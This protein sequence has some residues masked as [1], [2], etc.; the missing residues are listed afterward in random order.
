MG[1]GRAAVPE[2]HAAAGQ[3]RVAAGQNR[4]AAGQNRVAA[5]Q[6]RAAPSKISD[7]EQT[8]RYFESIKDDPPLLLAFLR[9]MP[10]GADLHNH[11]S[12]AVYAEDYIKMALAGRLC[13]NPADK[14]LSMPPCS[15]GQQI[16][17][18]IKLDSTLYDKLIDAWSMRNWQ[19][20]GESGHDHFFAAF[21]KFGAA[22][23]D[24]TLSEMLAAALGQAAADHVGSVELMFTPNSA[25]IRKIAQGRWNDD[26]ATMAKRIMDAGLAAEVKAGL[27]LVKKV[28]IEARARMGCKSAAPR[29]GC[30]VGLRFLFQGQRGSPREQAFALFLAG[31]EMVMHPENRDPWTGDPLVV[32]VNLVQP[33]D[34]LAAIQDFSAQMSMLD[35]LHTRYPKVHIALHAGELAPGLVVP[36]QLAFH[37]RESVERGHAERIGHGVDVMSEDRPYELLKELASRGVAVEICLS[38]NDQILGVRGR[39]H[40]LSAFIKYGVP[41]T[42]ATDDQGVARSSMTNEFLK[43]AQEQGLGYMELKAMAR[44]SLQYSFVEGE[45]LWQDPM[46]FVR[47]EPCRRSAPNSVS[48]E[49]VDFLRLSKKADL[50]WRLEQDF[51]EFESS[52]AGEHR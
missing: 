24:E 46:N 7:T 30:S 27:D 52:V 17:Q 41:V 43:A 20:S 1:Q 4:V 23:N 26:Y 28:T 44:T 49:C 34:S 35:Y 21:G 33:E 47:A 10:K 3:N 22:I 9:A 11:L 12:G 45:S 32:G 19:L 14:V 51:D 15:T 13:V 8:A 31:F 40:P 18:A 2:N 29:P 48:Q 5:G 38:S 36:A 39:Q 25:N 16:D 42:L 37:I 50:Q 6:N